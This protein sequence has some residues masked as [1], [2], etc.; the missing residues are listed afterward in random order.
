MRKIRR[1]LLIL[2]LI[3]G[4]S[5]SQN[6]GIKGA[7][8]IKR[9]SI[10]GQLD[11]CDRKGKQ[12][13]YFDL[14]RDEVPDV[15]KLYKKIESSKKKRGILVCVERDLNFDGRKDLFRYYNDEG[16]V[17]Q[18]EIDLDFDGKI[19][20]T[21]SFENGEIVEQQYDTDYDNIVDIW[22]YFEGGVPIRAEHDSD[23]DG[24]IDTWEYYKEG[25]VQRVGYDTNGDG[26]VDH[27]DRISSVSEKSE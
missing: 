25:H 23:K 22:I 6:T 7:E 19:D 27:W 24:K 5:S 15:W 18:E 10:S 8:T 4:C 12:E 17:I 13:L 14:N 26:Q 11:R 20:V 16:E 9:E 2:L 21:V 1:E 3:I